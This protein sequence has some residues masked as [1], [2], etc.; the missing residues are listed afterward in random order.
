MPSSADI[1]AVL[2][3]LLAAGAD[4]LAG[5]AAGRRADAIER[6][7]MSKARAVAFGPERRNRPSYAVL[8]RA[9]E[10]IPPAG[11]AALPSATG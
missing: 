5:S 4:V 10:T 8:R 1:T 9:V 6:S 11:V 2:D 7:K 3:V